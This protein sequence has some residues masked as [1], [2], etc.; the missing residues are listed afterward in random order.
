MT[1]QK[2]LITLILS[3]STVF[4]AQQDENKKILALKKPEIP[5][6]K[7][8]ALA[9]PIDRFVK[10]YFRNNGSLPSPAVS[11][12]VFIRRVYFDIWG[13]PPSG[14]ELD[15]FLW[16]SSLNKRGGL[17][18][19]LLADKDKYSEHWIS[20]W[21]DLLRN[22]DGVIYHTEDHKNRKSIT[23][24]LKKALEDNLPYDKFASSLLDPRGK[25]DPFGFLI[26]INWRGIASPSQSPIMQAAQNSAQVFLG[27][28]LKC[29][30]C[31]DSFVSRWKLKDAYDLAAFF[32]SENPRIYRCDISTGEISEPRF[33]FPR[34][35][36]KSIGLSL[37]ERRKTVANLFTTRKNGYFARTIVNRL[38]KKLIG[39]GI[40]EPVD[41]IEAL[42]WNKDLLDW[43]AVD[44]IEHRYDLKLT[45]RRI[46]TSRAYQL[47]TVDSPPA[48][49]KYIFRGP[50]FRRLTA[51]QYID[52]VHQIT[53]NLSGNQ[54]GQ[55]I[56]KR[57]WQKKAD[58]LTRALGRPI[59]D[60]VISQRNEEATTLQSLEL[61]NGQIL[62]E[63][64]RDKTKHIL[65][66]SDTPSKSPVEF[67]M[68][69][70]REALSRDPIP[71]EIEAAESFFKSFDLSP[72]EVEDFLWMI[73]LL[74]EF[75]YIR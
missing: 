15:E 11:D 51:E 7:N 66:S 12:S 47:P 29:N 46:M 28:N 36:P 56:R 5:H 18:D 37:E 41:N 71:R 57:E 10:S 42:P 35:Q 75:Q 14:K 40:V 21:N 23:P 39:R 16:D 53:E 70:Y 61:I 32:T 13:L 27:I 6:S 19:R 33:L 26:G 58:S 22:E 52:A 43:L 31:H 2:L 34:L 67:V 65:N 44:L 9:N 73:F 69:V 72:E 74:P 17:I 24:W 38:W 63:L 8:S 54:T 1:K 20:F 68:K 30:S 25:D 48:D 49:V 50:E 4:S 60:Q 62:S 55:Q 64:I 3:V 45:I 59:R